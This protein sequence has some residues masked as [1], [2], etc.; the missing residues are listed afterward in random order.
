MSIFPTANDNLQ[1]AITRAEI[2][3]AR[4]K[5]L[6]DEVKQDCRTIDAYS[7]NLTEAEAKLD[8]ALNANVGL[9]EALEKGLARE[10]ERAKL[11]GL[12]DCT[13]IN[14]SRETEIEYETGQCPHQ[15]ARQALSDTPAPDYMAVVKAA[16]KYRTTKT[17]RRA[18][19]NLDQQDGGGDG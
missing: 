1:A 11:F 12:S 3:E 2:A 10:T 4:V 13:C 15:L 18:L 16:R 19:A 6:E 7:E 8:A 9:R 5:E 14:F 17:A